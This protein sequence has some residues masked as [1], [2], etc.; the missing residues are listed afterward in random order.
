VWGDAAVYLP[1]DDHRALHELLRGLIDDEPRRVALG[2][3][4]RARAQ[5][6]GAAPMAEGYAAAYRELAALETIAC[7]S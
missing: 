2:A 7:A 3:R 4:A 1:P 6:L 5:A